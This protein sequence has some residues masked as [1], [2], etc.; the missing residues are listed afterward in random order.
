MKLCARLLVAQA[1]LECG[2]G[3]IVLLLLDGEFGF[4]V[5]L[6]HGVLMFFLLL[7]QK[8]LVGDGD[9]DLGFDLEELVF[10]VEDELFGELLRVFGFL[11]EVVDVGS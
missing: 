4:A 1:A 7:V 9:G 10:H 2:A 11:D 8:M 5:P 6:L 3:E